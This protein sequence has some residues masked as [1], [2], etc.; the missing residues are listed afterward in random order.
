MTGKINIVGFSR[1]S[2]FLEKDD[3]KYLKLIDVVLGGAQ[4][5]FFML[6]KQKIVGFYE[7]VSQNKKYFI[8]G[9]K[10]KK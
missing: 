6:D 8:D 4:Y 5:T 7:E 10:V 9:S 3:S 2:E 1:L